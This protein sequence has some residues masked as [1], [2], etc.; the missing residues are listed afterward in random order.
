[1]Q[2]KN[3]I[4]LTA[5]FAALAVGAG[6]VE[7]SV[8]LT[9]GWNAVYVKVAPDEPVAELF[10]SW[11]VNSVSVY[12]ADAYRY[13]V[14][15]AGG[16]TGEPTVRSPYWIWSREAPYA[17]AL[18][19]LSGDSVLVLFATNAEPFTATLQGRPA[20]PRLAWHVT[21]DENSASYN[22]AGVGL[23]GRVKLRDYF[24]GCP[25]FVSSGAYFMSGA[26][27]ASPRLRPVATGTKT[28]YLDDGD[29]VF[30]PGSAVSDWSGPLY[31]T[32]RFGIDFGEAGMLDEL[33]IR[34]DGAAEKTVNISYV[35]SV[36][37]KKRPELL[38]RESYA[39]TASAEWLPF[40][41]ALCRV[42]S[43]G[44]TYRVALA[45]DRSKARGSGAELGG[46]M[47]VFETGGT[48]MHTAIPV[49]ARD[50]R[51]ASVWPQG[52][53]EAKI[54][55]S[56][57]SFYVSDTNRV[58]DVAAGGAMDFKV[59]LHVDIQGAVRLLQR[60]T[61]GG[62]KDSDGNMS[63][64]IYAPTATPP[65]SMSYSTRLSSVA[66]P[67]DL[68]ETVAT[69]GAFGD[70]TAPLVFNYTIGAKS[71][72]NPFRH[73]L[74]P[75]FDGKK[76]DF[77]DDAPDGDDFS[78]YTGSVKPELFSI[79]GEVRF[80]FDDNAANA[81]TPKETLSG[82]C[83]WIYTGVRRDGPVVAKGSFK[84]TQIAKTAEINLK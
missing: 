60:V 15:A 69:G 7:Q 73:A 80:A 76:S 75:M 22:I 82:E 3:M 23:S 39:E 45:F 81:W 29:V 10:A 38:Y 52:L 37:G 70:N 61:V 2:S 57:V 54:R 31:V 41:N 46:V 49:S 59:Y 74:H 14:S 62:L 16:N 26:D 34:N 72:S 42:L 51:L 56:R 1:M 65:S 33:T 24:A 25:A 12:N 50:V 9:N 30:L 63:Q 5:V 71:P 40:T 13:T 44:E 79:G 64:T 6:H 17:S 66:L 4:F 68:P 83:T 32:P 19:S 84:M 27:E 47:N 53:W 67:V 58:D 55:L 11:P 21:T 20:A 28:A 77:K 18:R 78:N 8:T 48:L 35:D 36:D 43:T